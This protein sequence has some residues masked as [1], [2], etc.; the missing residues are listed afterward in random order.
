MAPPGVHRLQCRL[1]DRIGVLK[2]D[3]S[4]CLMPPR[5]GAGMSGAT[6][7]VAWFVANTRRTG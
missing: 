1:A 5:R 4:E 2:C 3:D 7:S 6:A